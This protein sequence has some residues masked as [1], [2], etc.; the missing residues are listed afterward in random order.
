MQTRLRIIGM[1]CRKCVAA[2][3]ASLESVPGVAAVEV[4]FEHGDATVDH[5]AGVTRESLMEQVE[6]AGYDCA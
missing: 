4:S 5:D 6:A 3:Q 2:L 1:S